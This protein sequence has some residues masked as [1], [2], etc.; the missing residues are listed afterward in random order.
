MSST[1]DYYIEATD[2]KGNVSRSMILHVYVGDGNGSGPVDPDQPSVLGSYTLSPA[3]PTVDDVITITAANGREGMIL[4][5][6][7]NKFEKPIQAYLPAGSQYHSDGK[8]ARTPFTL[9]ADGKYEVK[10]GPFNNPEQAVSY[11]SFVTNTG[12]D[13]DNN[14]GNDYR[15]NLDANSGAAEIEAA[16]DAVPEYY[17]LQ[18]VRVDNPTSG[19]Y[20]CRKGSK[21]TKVFIR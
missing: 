10:I 8:A 1:K 7:V 3:K 15:F 2:T 12:N 9:N 6:G 19:I 16:A 21:V 13:W 18:G 20:L 11:I 5:W 4:H 14:G 17:T